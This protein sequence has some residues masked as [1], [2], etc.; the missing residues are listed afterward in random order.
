MRSRSTDTRV[1]RDAFAETSDS[2]TNGNSAARLTR[3]VAK[4]ATPSS[5]E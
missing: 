4:T 2:N 3:G 5:G 1:A